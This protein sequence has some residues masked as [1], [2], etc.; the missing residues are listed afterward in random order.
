MDPDSLTLTDGAESFAVTVLEA[1]A[2]VRTVLFA[3]GAG[4]DPKRH[5][6]LLT[7]L[8]ERSCTVVAPHFE[9]PL[10]PKTIEFIE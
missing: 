4:G 10:D 9:R 3:V 7:S 8:A 1:A 5:L 6:P 2:P